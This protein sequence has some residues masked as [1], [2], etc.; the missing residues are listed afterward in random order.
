MPGGQRL[1]EKQDVASALLEQASLFIH[2]DPRHEDVRVP[3]WFKSQPQLVLQV[4][5]NLAVPIHDLAVEDDAIS[6]TL[7]FNR[8]PF[9]CYVP[10]PAV[11]ALVGED[12]RGMVWPDDVPAE[13]ASQMGAAPKKQP[14]KRPV[15]R[16]V[17]DGADEA[18]ADDT[19]EAGGEDAADDAPEQRRARFKLAEATT[20]AGGPPAD[21]SEGTPEPASA[22]ESTATTEPAPPQQASDEAEGDD[23]GKRKLP[24][25][26]R[27]VK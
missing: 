23:E 20:E 8:S 15:L 16:A 25:Y 19:A 13:V 4:G 3:K 21:D 9:F 12:G 27:V 7:S 14:E 6:G 5:F 22:G 1:P 26:L 24:P 2:L 10:W 11:F 17:P 18:G